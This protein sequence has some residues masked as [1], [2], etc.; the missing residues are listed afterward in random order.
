[1]AANGAAGTAPLDRWAD[2]EEKGGPL[3][4]LS[5]QDGEPFFPIEV[6]DQERRRHLASLSL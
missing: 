6:R 3:R 4:G 5:K 1:M 2:A